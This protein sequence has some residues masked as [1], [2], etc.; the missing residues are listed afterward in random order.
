LPVLGAKTSHAQGVRHPRHPTPFPKTRVFGQTLS[1]AAAL[2]NR[3]EGGEPK[4][5]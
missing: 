5:I 2:K 3:P 1:N 4:A